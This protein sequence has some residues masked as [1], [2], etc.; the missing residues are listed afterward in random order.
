MRVRQSQLVRF[1]FQFVDSCAYFSATGE[2]PPLP[3]QFS[4]AVLANVVMG[5]D[6]ENERAMVGLV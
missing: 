4:V 2:Q 1:D 3:S 5:R 6:Q